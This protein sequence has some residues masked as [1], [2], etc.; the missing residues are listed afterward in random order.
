MSK[1]EENKSYVLSNL[2]YLDSKQCLCEVL[3]HS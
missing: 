2:F 3:P 1:E